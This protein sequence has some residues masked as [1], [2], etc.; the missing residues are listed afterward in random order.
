M[1]FKKFSPLFRRVLVEVVEHDGVVRPIV[2]IRERLAAD[3]FLDER[4]V[5]VGKGG[6]K[7]VKGLFGKLM[8]A[9]QHQHLD[10][11][12]GSGFGRVV[13]SRNAA[14]TCDAGKQ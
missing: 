2:D 3:F 11:F 14:E 12:R 7:L 1:S 10:L 9:H 4:A 5:H 6:E 8:P 13:G